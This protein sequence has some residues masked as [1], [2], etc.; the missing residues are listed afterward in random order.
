MPYGSH[1]ARP[2]N[3]SLLPTSQHYTPHSEWTQGLSSIVAFELRY[4]IR[5]MMTPM[6]IDMKE[7]YFIYFNNL[8]SIRCLPV[9][10]HKHSGVHERSRLHVPIMLGWVTAFLSGNLVIISPNTEH[11]IFNVVIFCPL[12]RFVILSAWVLFV[13]H[14]SPV[15]G[16]L[17]YIC[18]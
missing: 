4:N 15:P 6:V 3:V 16:N 14:L 12:V 13:L 9:N 18:S 8:L 11:L 2:L 17:T 1:T 7:R 5:G 10:Q